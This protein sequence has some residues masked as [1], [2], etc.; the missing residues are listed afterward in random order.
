[1]IGPWWD[2]G[3]RHRRGW[4]FIGSVGLVVFV[5]S[6]TYAIWQLVN[7][8]LKA[9]ETAGLL[10][11][12]VGVTGF[13]AAIAALRRPIEGN[14]AELARGW[15]KTLARQVETSEGLRR[16]ERVAGFTIIERTRP[17]TATARVQAFLRRAGAGTENMRPEMG[18]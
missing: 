14:D 18:P 8:G 11:L 13:V 4:Q 17:L 5:A 16:I 15:A 7:G 12:P 3:T 6:V 9:D 2:W 1:M 10:G